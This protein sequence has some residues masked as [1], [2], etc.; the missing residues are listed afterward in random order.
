[1]S[2]RAVTTAII[3]DNGFST[4]R[5]PIS[6]TI[7]KGFTPIG[8]CPVVDYVVED[9][10]SA[11]ITDIYFVIHQY[12]RDIYD[13]YFIG[14]EVLDHYLDEKG[15]TEELNRLQALRAR[16]NFHMIDRPAPVGKYGTAIPP[17]M[18][19]EEIL[20]LGTC[21]YLASDDFTVRSDGGNDIADLLE[22]FGRHQGAVGALTGYDLP[23]EVLSN[24]GVMGLRKSGE[25]WVLR[26]LIEKPT[27]PEKLQKPLLAN[28]S[29]HIIGKEMWPYFLKLESNPKQGEYYIVDIYDQLANEG[30]D[31]VVYEAKGSYFDVGTLP[32]WLLA[33]AKLAEE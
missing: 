7:P 4:R 6:A 21:L 20:S 5:L 15:K 31:I 11:G 14:N 33:N 24:V 3:G 9:L 16:A 1:M 26:D 17:L 2:K 23:E 13:R 19:Y 10:V 30:K 28:I 18:V 12:H 32:N 22:A 29:K 27:H 25:S 8:N